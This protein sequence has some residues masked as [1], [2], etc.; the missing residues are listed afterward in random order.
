MRRYAKERDELDERYTL[1]TTDRQ[2]RQF[3]GVRDWTLDV[4]AC[5]ASHLAA[6][7]FTKADD[8]LRKRWSGRVWC[9]PPFSNCGVW[10]AKAW[11]ES[12]RCEVI[13]MLLPAVRTDLGWWQRLVEPFRDR[14][15]H[16]RP[17]L[18]T[19]HFLPGRPR[20]RS[21]GGGKPGSPPFGCV[22]LLWRSR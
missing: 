8:G 10:V 17:A 22:L 9:N 18:L 1:D 14:R 13:A 15:D 19:A 7:Y 2:C 20:F 3:A 21:P 11:A 16:H 4:A 5:P 12:T 6:K